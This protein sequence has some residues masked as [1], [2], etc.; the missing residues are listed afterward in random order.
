M[1]FITLCCFLVFAWFTLSGLVDAKS[2]G[3]PA[4]QGQVLKRASHFSLF[5]QPVYQINEIR[6]A[7]IGDY[8]SGSAD[9]AAV[10]G[11][12]KSW[13][14]DFIITTGDNNYPSGAA[15]TIDRNIGQF[16][17][18][19]IN[20]YWGTYPISPA[21]GR[22]VSTLEDYPFRVY[23]P[24]VQT[25]II[26]P[27]R[28]FPTLGN[29]DWQTS[30][31]TPYL[32]YFTLPGNERYYDFVRGPV[33]LFA[34]DSDPHEPDGITSSST[35]A[36]W[37]RDKLAASTACWQLV[38]FHHAPFSSGPHGSNSSMQWPFASWGADV[39]LA[40][41]DHTYE[42]IV[43]DSLPYF[44]NGLGGNGM[45]AFQ[46]TPVAG[47]EVRYNENFGA[48]LV[49]ATPG[50]ITYQ[51]ITTAGLVIDTYTQTGWCS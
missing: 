47:S 46:P 44:V 24:L 14:P 48:M 39:V 6:F 35:Q 37:L 40:G 11:L 15:D 22:L 13:N 8:G 17:Y 2:D 1:R 19:F 49:T 3:I 50:T 10:A 36:Q 16:Y 30:G 43:L 21:A 9:E 29:H 27:N 31:A 23:L 51:F 7:I 32:D 4:Q 42:R 25:T 12:V 20:P 41:H 26:S 5:F 34:L 33:H 45:Y 38:Y 28:F 18:D